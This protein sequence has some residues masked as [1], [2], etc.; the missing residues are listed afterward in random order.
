MHSSTN[1]WPAWRNAKKEN[2]EL[3]KQLH[4]K[5]NIYETSEEEKEILIT[6]VQKLKVQ[7]KELILSGTNKKQE[8]NEKIK[9]LN[10]EYKT[11][12]LENEEKINS[13]MKKIELYSEIINSKKDT[14]TINNQEKTFTSHM[15]KDE[16]NKL[17]VFVGSLPL[18]FK[19]IDLNNLFKKYGEIKRARVLTTKN[20]QNMVVS[21]CCGFVQFSNS[22]SA[23]KSIKE[24]NGTL[25]YG[26][27]FPILIEFSKSE[28]KK[29][30]EDRYNMFNMIYKN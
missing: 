10:E 22:E 9:N 15:E 2:D 6:I 29:D 13:V 25:P 24:L 21:K 3:K 1:G 27:K 30:D 19:D 18:M 5:P 23:L 11:F 4:E 20:E 14:L 16:N 12:E 26:F 7:T 28:R 17:E 8:F